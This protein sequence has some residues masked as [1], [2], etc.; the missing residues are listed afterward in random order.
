MLLLLQEHLPGFVS[1]GVSSRF[2][3]ADGMLT[4][5]NSIHEKGAMST[6]KCASIIIK[7]VAARKREV[8]MTFEG[9]YGL[10][11]ILI[12]P[13]LVDRILRKKALLYHLDKK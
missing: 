9:K 8:V 7:S 3:K 10:W 12:A 1:T 5:K 2:I 6:E 13:K 4:G 11:L